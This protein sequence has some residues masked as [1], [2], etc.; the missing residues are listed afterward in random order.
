MPSTANAKVIPLHKNPA[1]MT[2][3]ELFN[4]IQYLKRGITKRA[5]ERGTFDLISFSKEARELVT[6]VA[7]SDREHLA[8][9]LPI[10]EQLRDIL[11]L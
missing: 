2:H 7:A 4:H 6:R 8:L 5:E 11:G 1:T 9:L 3:R 10:E